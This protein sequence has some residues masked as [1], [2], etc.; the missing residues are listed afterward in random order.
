MAD[1]RLPHSP[2]WKMPLDAAGK[3]PE[4]MP[5]KRG[6]VV[7]RDGCP[8]GVHPLTRYAGVRHR[9]GYPLLFRLDD[10]GGAPAV[11]SLAATGLSHLPSGY[12]AY[13]EPPNTVA[14]IWVQ[15][16]SNFRGDQ[17]FQ[18]VVGV[19]SVY[20][21]QDAATDE[22]FAPV[23]STLGWSYPLVVEA[24]LDIVH[25]LALY[26]YESEDASHDRHVIFI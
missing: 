23:L 6:Y 3:L 14:L 19:R 4:T 7:V 2:Q 13:I 15:S 8:R 9:H 20:V 16:R 24:F 5:S 11:A 12:A 18:L 1:M 22:L 25:G 17:L 10:R 26:A 21:V